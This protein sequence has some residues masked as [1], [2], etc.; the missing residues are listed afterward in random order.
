MLG[1]IIINVETSS[2]I[3]C[4]MLKMEIIDRTQWHI[5]GAEELRG[6]SRK[7]QL[8]LARSKIDRKC[9]IQAMI[10]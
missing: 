9:S 10:R 6:K 7:P 5:L 4:L 8:G 2:N 1:E 3:S